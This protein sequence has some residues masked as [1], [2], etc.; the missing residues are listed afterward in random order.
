MKKIIFIIVIVGMLG[1]ATYEFISSKDEASEEI[2]ENTG[3]AMITSPAPDQGETQNSMNTGLTKGDVA[4]DFSLKTLDG[5]TVHLSDFKGK[6]VLVNFWATWC[7]PCRAEIP[8]LQKLY[9]KKD[10]TILAVNLTASEK[11]EATVSDFVQEFEMSF[12]VLKDVDEDV[13][14]AY[15]VRAYPTSYMIDSKGRIQFVALGAM[16]YDQMVQELEKMK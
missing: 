4:P 5:E 13:S 10:V 7:P 16:N 2:K 11:N 15:Q 14:T 8:D 6:R 12:P 9:N 1:Y 3:G